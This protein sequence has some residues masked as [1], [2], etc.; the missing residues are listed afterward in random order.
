MNNDKQKNFLKKIKNASANKTNDDNS[1]ANNKEE[2]DKFL[3]SGKHF[4][5]QWNYFRNEKYNAGYKNYDSN[6]S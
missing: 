1:T 5:K 4:L 3:D 6:L 2:S